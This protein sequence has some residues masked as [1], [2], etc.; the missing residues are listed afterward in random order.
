MFRYMS[1]L[2]GGDERLGARPSFPYSVLDELERA[3]RVMSWGEYRLELDRD[4]DLE[5]M[6]WVMTGGMCFVVSQ[7]LRELLERKTPG[8]IQ[9]LPIQTAFRGKPM[10][11]VKYW[12][13]NVL[14]MIS[15]IDDERSEWKPW[16]P[17]SKGKFYIRAEI[18]PNKVP[19][20][21]Q[22]FRPS[23]QRMSVYVR[24]ELVEDIENAGMTGC[25]FRNVNIYDD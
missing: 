3:K 10:P 9:F 19:Q 15:C 4:H 1:N 8:Q 16:Y 20:E 23:E 7:R 11:K 14:N 13:V 21:L 22:I 2:G 6:P 17:G 12:V 5:D 18:D 25:R 24:R